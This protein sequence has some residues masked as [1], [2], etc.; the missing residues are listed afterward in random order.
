MTILMVIMKPLGLHLQL[1]ALLV[2][3]R[4]F[5]INLEMNL[6][7]GDLVHQ[8]NEVVISSMELRRMTL[9]SQ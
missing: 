1:L 6:V 5:S 8:M 3:S 2:F 4:S 9:R 7:I